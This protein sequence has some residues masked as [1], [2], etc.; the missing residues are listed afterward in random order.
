MKSAAPSGAKQFAEKRP[1]EHSLTSAAEAVVEKRPDIAAVNRCATQKQEQD[2]V[3]Q[4]GVKP[5]CLSVLGGTA[6][7]VPFPRRFMR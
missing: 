4:Q 7:A 2:R 3:F 1:F 6:E 5:A